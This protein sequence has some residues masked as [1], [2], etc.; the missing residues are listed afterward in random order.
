MSEKREKLL[1]ELVSRLKSAHGAALESVILYGSAASGDFSER[2]SDLNVFCVLAKVGVK[3]LE[4]AEKIFAWW[5][6]QGNPAPLLMSR[7]EVMRSA[8]CFPIEFHDMAERRRVLHGADIIAS[9]DIDDRFYRAQVEMELRAKLLRLRQ[10]AA[11]VL[12]QP[13]LLTGLMADS[14]STFALLVRHALRLHGETALSHAKREV[15]AAAQSRLS[16]DAGPFYTLLD[17]REGLKRPKDVEPRALFERY[18]AGLVA[19]AEAVD[20][21]DSKE[22][23]TR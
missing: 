15:F 19:M 11:G 5:R 6:D 8:D 12:Q 14:I 10:K 2:F 1:A 3:E 23:E 21:L 22:N 20:R 7:N 9:V 18:L 16:V 17:L 4:A 13:D